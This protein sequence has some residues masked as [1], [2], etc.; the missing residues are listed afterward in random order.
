L[1]RPPLLGLL[2]S[3]PPAPA[4]AADSASPAASRPRV[5]LVLAGGGAKG[6]AHIGVIKVLEELRVPVDVVV[7]TSMGSIVAGAYATGLSGAEMERR[8][9][10]ADLSGVLVD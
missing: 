3:L 9:R 6:I 7:G 10:A 8:V 4:A 5:G 1:R 2:L